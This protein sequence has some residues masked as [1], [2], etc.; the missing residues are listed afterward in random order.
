MNRPLVR[1]WLT[2]AERDLEAA[3]R[4]AK[5]EELLDLAIY[6]CQQGA[7]KALKGFLIFHDVAFE[8]VHDLRLLNALAM[9]VEARFSSWQDVAEGL[10]P[11]AT[12]FRYPDDRFE[13]Q[14]DEFD[15]ALRAATDLYQFILSLLPPEAR[16]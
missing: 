5:P 2:K 11:Y 16:P 12:E 8:K 9:A 14:R 3:N 6:H 15:Q 10:T 7:E 4:L 1:E 13:P